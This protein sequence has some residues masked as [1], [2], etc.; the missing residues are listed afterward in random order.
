MKRDTGLTCKRAY[1]SE[2]EQ[3]KTLRDLYTSN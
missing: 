2:A 3:S 1:N